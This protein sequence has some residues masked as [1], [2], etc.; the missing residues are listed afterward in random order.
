MGPTCIGYTSG[1]PENQISPQVGQDDLF[2]VLDVELGHA[3]LIRNFLL[4]QWNI[5]VQPT[6]HYSLGI[7]G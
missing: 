1:P 7:E 4:I 2:G 5:K 3:D 6:S